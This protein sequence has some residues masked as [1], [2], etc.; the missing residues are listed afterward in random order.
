MKLII[1]GEDWISFFER[2]T[3]DG[4][5]GIFYNGTWYGVLAYIIVG[6][7]C[8]FAVIGLITVISLI[9]RPRK[10]K[11]SSSEKWLKTGKW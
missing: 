1:G 5:I 2:M 8:L 7:I 3:Y 6:L 4:A 10:P 11:M 9:F